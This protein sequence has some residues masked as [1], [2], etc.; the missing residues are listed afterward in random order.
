M[1]SRRPGFSMVELLIV[2]T[3]L[4]VT[5]AMAFP[6]LSGVNAGTDV[7][8]AQGAVAATVARARAA[9]I[10]RGRPARA[11]VGKGA[12]WTVIDVYSGPT[13]LGAASQLD[14]LF[15]VKMTVDGIAAT[16][17]AFVE[18]DARGLGRQSGATAVQ[19]NFSSSKRV[20]NV[21]LLPTGRVTLVVCGA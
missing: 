13:R 4:G 5:A 17:S 3:V 19:V 10:Q 21:C 15:K 2:L 18:F 20:G 6:K 9:A 12:A 7:R 11:Y 1:L 16:D 14:S 8:N